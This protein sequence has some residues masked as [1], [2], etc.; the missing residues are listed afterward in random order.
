MK[1]K[2]TNY[3]YPDQ[4]LNRLKKISAETGLPVSEIIRRAIDKLLE[5]EVW[6]EDKK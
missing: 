2:R 4:M 6:E 1:M 3:Y 5:E